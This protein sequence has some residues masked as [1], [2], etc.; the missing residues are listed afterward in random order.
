MLSFEN[1]GLLL[2]QLTARVAALSAASSSFRLRVILVYV[3]IFV[4][5]YVPSSV[6]VS[7]VRLTRSIVSIVIVAGMMDCSVRR[8]RFSILGL[9]RFDD[10]EVVCTNS[11]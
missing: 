4:M 9:K 1:T 3:T 5:R 11:H 8:I 6:M 7:Y 2:F 10:D